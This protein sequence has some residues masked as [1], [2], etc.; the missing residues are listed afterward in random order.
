MQFIS[1]V[2][3]SDIMQGWISS[4]SVRYLFPWFKIVKKSVHSF[5]G[6]TLLNARKLLTRWSAT[7]TTTFQLLSQNLISDN[8]PSTVKPTKWFAVD[9]ISG[10]ITLKN[11]LDREALCGEMLDCLIHLQVYDNTRYVLCGCEGQ[12]L[13]T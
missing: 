12:A 10:K 5:T 8:E 9:K 6:L 13:I 4:T 1:N 3:T 2:H 7:P 11:R